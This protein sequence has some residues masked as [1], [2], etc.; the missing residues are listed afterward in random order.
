[1]HHSR[2]RDV[3][4]I[5]LQKVLEL[6]TASSVS[7]HLDEIL[8]LMAAF[9]ALAPP[10]VLPS[11]AS[12]L[13]RSFPTASDRLTSIMDYYGT[14]VERAFVIIYARLLHEPLGDEDTKAA[15]QVSNLH[16][17]TNR[18]YHQWRSLIAG[19]GRAKLPLVKYGSRTWQGIV[20]WHIWSLRQNG[21]F[22][23]DFVDRTDPN[24]CEEARRDDIE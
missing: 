10:H 12:R 16:I 19:W 15:W 18:E 23:E 14:L 3:L 9:P 13:R 20:D 7:K 6:M 4:D 17:W 22:G 24:W 21:G 5:I 11:A 8:A 2:R 1:M